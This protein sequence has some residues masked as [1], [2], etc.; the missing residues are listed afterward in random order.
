MPLLRFD[1]TD[2]DWLT[3]DEA[4]AA[5]T[6]EVTEVTEGGSVP[7]LRYLMVP[8]SREALEREVEVALD[9]LRP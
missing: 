7:T 1:A 5:G 9:D 6:L 8:L 4:I 2:P 3:L